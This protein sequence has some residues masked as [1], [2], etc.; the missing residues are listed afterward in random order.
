MSAAIIGIICAYTTSI[1]L[2]PVHKP[3]SPKNLEAFF[4][5]TFLDAKPGRRSERVLANRIRRA[6]CFAPMRIL[7]SKK[8]AYHSF[9]E[10][11]NDNKMKKIRIRSLTCRQLVYSK[12]SI[13]KTFEAK[14]WIKT[15]CRKGSHF[16]QG[17]VNR[18]LER[19]GGG[20]RL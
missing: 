7:R 3:K 17:G 5:E 11:N 6:R 18:S 15:K 4:L 1:V 19:W 8:L 10:E 14:G 2:D 12:R 20:K 16:Q 13:K 9:V